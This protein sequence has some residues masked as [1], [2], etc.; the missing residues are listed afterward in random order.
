ME[1]PWSAAMEGTDRHAPG[2]RGTLP[3]RPAPA[4]LDDIHA[5]LDLVLAAVAAARPG[6]GVHT[7]GILD[8]IG[9]T[10]RRARDLI[11][12]LQR[13]GEPDEV[14]AGTPTDVNALLEGLRSRLTASLPPGVDLRMRLAPGLWPAEAEAARPPHP[15]LRSRGMNALSTMAPAG[16]ALASPADGDPLSA[17]FTLTIGAGRP[18][19][20]E[21]DPARHWFEVI[22]GAVRALQFGV[23][24]RRQLVEIYLPGDVFG[25]DGLDGAHAFTAEATTASSVVLRRSCRHRLDA[26]CAANAALANRV[27]HIAMRSL[28][29]AYRRLAELG[30]HGARERM[31]AFLLE[32]EDRLAAAEAERGGPFALPMC[33]GDIADYLGLARETV[34]RMLHDFQRRDILRLS[35]PRRIGILDHAALRALAGCAAARSHGRVDATH[36]PA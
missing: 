2:A 26:A 28:T 11:E 25:F 22:S 19:Y 36:T 35:G 32:M 12:S 18:I 29:R 1:S 27:R 3:M 8:D 7:T 31:A 34:S 30:L 5:M 9:G 20:V 23:D 15:G 6:A 4:I 10:T 17:Y 24:G 13:S 21:G 16:E 33:R 14:A